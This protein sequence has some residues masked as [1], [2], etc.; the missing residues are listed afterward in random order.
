MAHDLI[1]RNGT[2][3]DGT[4]AQGYRADVAIDGDRITAIGDLSA[5]QATREIDASGLIVS[6]GFIDLHTHLDAQVAWDPMMTSSSWHG[7]TTVLIGNCGVTF[8]PVAPDHRVF[9]AEMMESVEDVPREAILGGLSWDWSTYPEYL[10]AVQGMRPALNIVGLVGH[11]AVRYNVMGERSLSDQPPSPEELNRMRDIVQESIAGGAVGFSTSR[12]LL[13]TVPDGR[14]VPG[15]LAPIDEYMAIAD[16]MN[17]AGGGLFQAVND[18]ATKAEHEVTLLREMARSCGDVLFSGGAGNSSNAGVDMFG[19]LLADTNANLGRMTMASQTRPSGSLCGLA[20]IAPVKGQKWKALMGLPTLA[21]RV[22]ALKDPAT[23]AALVEEGVAKGLWYDANHI[24][25]L[26]TGA[27]PDYSETGGRSVAT[28]AA[29]LGVH[30]VDY[31]ID[32]LIASDGHEL[33]NTWFFNR[34]VDGLAQVLAMDNV[35]P[36]LADTGAHAGQICDADMSTHYLTYWQRERQ[37]ATLPEAVRRLSAMPASV[38]GLKERGTLQ[39]GQFAD[40]N[41]FD[42]DTLASDQPT[43]VN[44]FPNGAGRLQ[45]RARGYAATI[46][47]GAIVTEQ[48]NNTGERPGRV[49]REFARS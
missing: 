44:D 45:I 5:A 35:Y 24:Y 23:R 32:R 47:N 43:Y 17:A 36:G 29:E 48:G 37:L 15:T 33:F 16:G 20:Q 40:V 14:Y 28:R 26:G 25:P 10:D 22:A 4:G 12:I 41:V 2:I 31:V 3:I 38:L 7:V 18:F 13:H 34:N 46:V 19:A 39:V 27:S 1:I 6:P 9:L 49:I 30:P 42:I 11:C 21:D 8:A